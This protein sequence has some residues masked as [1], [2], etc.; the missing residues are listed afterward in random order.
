[1]GLIFV[2]GLTLL[3][4][5]LVFYKGLKLLHEAIVFQV[6]L[7]SVVAFLI[8]L[9]LGIV[10]VRRVKFGA[11]FLPLWA[12]YVIAILVAGAVMVFSFKDFVAISSYPFDN[13]YTPYIDYLEP[14]PLSFP[15][16]VSNYTP[17]VYSGAYPSGVYFFNVLI[18]LAPVKL[19]YLMNGFY[20]MLNPFFSLTITFH[21]FGP[22][23]FIFLL[24]FSALLMGLKASYRLQRKE[25]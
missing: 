24:D 13:P 7:P 1:L 9:V 3:E 11:E 6:V 20:G 8:L 15:F 22:F 12:V 23:I 10:F 17:F 2:V 25:N 21:Y 18:F 16:V 4:P 19:A 5:N 14:L